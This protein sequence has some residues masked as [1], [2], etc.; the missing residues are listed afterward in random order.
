MTTHFSMTT[1]SVVMTKDGEIVFDTDAYPVQFFPTGEQIELTGQTITFPDLVKG[2]AYNWAVGTLGGSDVYVGCASYITLAPQEWGP[3]VSGELA[4]TNELAETV[5]GTVPE[6]TD[7]LLV[8]A[9]LN[10]TTTPSQING[11]TIP[12]L[13]QSGEYVYCPGGS[14]PVEYLAP[15]S[16]S[17]EVVLDGTNVVLRRRQS[18][19]RKLYTF[20]RTDNSSTQSGWTYGG[21]AGKY[22]HP[23]YHLQSLGPSFDP[24][25]TGLRRGAGCSLTDTSNYSSV[26]SADFIIVPGKSNITPEGG[27]LDAGVQMAFVGEDFAESSSDPWVFPIET[28]AARADR[29][30]IVMVGFLHTLDAFK[31]ISSVTIGGVT[32]TAVAKRVLTRN[33]GGNSLT[34]RGAAIYIANVPNT[35]GEQDVSVNWTSSPKF[36]YYAAF[37]AYGLESSS[38]VDIVQASGATTQS[39]DTQ[40]D[41]V[42]L[43]LSTSYSPAFPSVSG[44][45]NLVH[46]DYTTSSPTIATRT[47]RG[48]QNTTGSTL[49][50]SQATSNLDIPL[51]AASFR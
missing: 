3:I 4:P 49:S 16:R 12:V 10:R 20:W 23:V 37:V 34:T 29:R 33:N 24:S 47:A 26:Y 40:D 41:G 2:D 6:G 50:I 7:I 13:P 25:G 46:Q 17:I 36:A 43:A 14:L 8:F 22:G 44:I 45:E 38:P 19:T 1:D 42:A 32:A 21:S 35:D 15:L 9:K 28:I 39:L 51:V 11:N 30:I 31:D 27:E 18:V 48:F 5:I